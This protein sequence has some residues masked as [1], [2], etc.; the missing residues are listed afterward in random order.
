MSKSKGNRRDA[1]WVCFEEHGADGVR[2]GRRQ[3][4]RRRHRIF[5]PAL[6]SQMKIGRPLASRS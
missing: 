6:P 5:D 2:T 4:A 1:V 3:R